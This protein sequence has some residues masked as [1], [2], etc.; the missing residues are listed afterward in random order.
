MVWLK[1]AL[2]S[3]ATALVRKRKI[4]KELQTPLAFGS[5]DGGRAA[6]YAGSV[7]HEFGGLRDQIC[8]TQ[9]RTLIAAAW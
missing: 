1:S 3:R 4:Q 5:W 8:T 6:G 9:A 7:S 2:L